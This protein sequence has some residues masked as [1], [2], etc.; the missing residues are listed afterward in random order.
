MDKL[1][2][3]LDQVCRGIGGPRSLRQHIRREL[4]E[5]LQD[6]AAGH[7]A[8]GRPEEEALARALE[9]F[10]GPEQVRSELEAT[11]GHRLM[12]LVVDRA[13]QWKEMTLKARWLWASWSHLALLGVIAL[14]VFWIAFVAYFI[15]PKFK[16]LMFLGLVDP[17]I[18]D[19]SAVSWMPAFLGRLERAVQ[20]APIW[21]LLAA[22]A[23]GLFEWLV[24]GE[25]KSFMRLS[26]LGT[27]A[28]GLMI[29]II[30]A[31]GSLL[32]PFCLGA[33]AAFEMARPFALQ[34]IAIIDASVGELER[35]LTRQDWE[36]MH[37]QADLASRAIV[38]LAGPGPALHSL[39]SPQKPPNVEEL[40]SQLEATN[41]RLR[42]AQDAIREKDPE[43]L[44]AALQKFRESYGP[45]REAATASGE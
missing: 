41:D 9:D 38:R 43:R 20:N 30:L 3:Y 44:K 18:L 42:E 22:A 14:E 28:A 32:I 8:A 16:H 19:K 1:E 33:S 6:A 25:N 36:A 21:A 15:V 39:G 31:A 5:H 27:A 29:V 17:L 40:R 10:G 23:W 35:G 34:Q 24:R 7:R 12:T 26:A 11:H 37:E 4:R 45:V 13:M 2:R